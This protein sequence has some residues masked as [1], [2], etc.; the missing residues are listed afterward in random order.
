[1]TPENTTDAPRPEAAD[2]AT[3][4]ARRVV[5]AEDET[6]IRLDV[7]EILRGEGYEVVAEADNGEKAVALAQEHRPDLVLMDVKMPV[8][9]GITTTFPAGRS[10]LVGLIRDTVPEGQRARMTN[11][12]MA[13]EAAVDETVFIFGPVVVGLL[14]TLSAALSR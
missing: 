4:P 1:M 5:V 10:G 9:D 13:Y 11:G 8:L 2:P 12:V 6:L 7:V 14:A 3:A